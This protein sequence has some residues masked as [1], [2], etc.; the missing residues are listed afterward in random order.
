M[1]TTAPAPA[2]AGAGDPSLAPVQV[3]RCRLEPV[4]TRPAAPRPIS[5]PTEAAAYL[6]RVIPAGADRM[7]VYALA[8]DVKNQ[9]L[10]AYEVAVGTL[11]A[12]LLCPRN[13][14]KAAILLN[15]H[16][17]ILGLNHV[18]GDPEPSL[19]TATVA[20]NLAVACHV[21]GIPLRDFIILGADSHVSLDSATC[22]RFSPWAAAVSST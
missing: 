21:V 20:R 22:P 12:A 8:L 1:Q 19:D 15:A 4:G 3:Y 11:D 2:R 18:S 6:R 14:L 16:S 5:T 13:C 7:H 10:G 9:V 17:L